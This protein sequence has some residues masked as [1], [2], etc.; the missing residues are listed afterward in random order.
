MKC[1]RC[2]TSF[3]ASNIAYKNEFN[4][5]YFYCH[6][7]YYSIQNRN[8]TNK[9]HMLFAIVLHRLISL[10][11]QVES[12][13]YDEWTIGHVDFFHLNRDR[14][15][16]PSD[17]SYFKVHSTAMFLFVTCRGAISIW[18]YHLLKKYTQRKTSQSTGYVYFYS[19]PTRYSATC[20]CRL[21]L[22]FMSIA[23]IS[24]SPSALFSMAASWPGSCISLPG[25]QLDSLA[26]GT[27]QRRPI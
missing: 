15:L 26:P 13:C 16:L 19:S 8:T 5:L 21:S 6:S 10:N 17:Q 7:L 23:T 25:P 1:L 4:Y 11:S 22:S 2:N 20:G 14:S 24:S 12:H 18:S 9:S 27:R 3:L